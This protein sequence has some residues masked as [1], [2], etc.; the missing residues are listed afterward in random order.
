MEAKLERRGRFEKFFIRIYNTLVSFLQV[1][2]LGC[3]RAE[4]DRSYH[5]V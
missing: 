1:Q 3:K 5:I 4:M 2:V